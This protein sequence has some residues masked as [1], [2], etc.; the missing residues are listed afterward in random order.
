M[1]CIWTSHGSYRRTEYRNEKDLESAVLAVQQE[2][3]GSGR[4]YLDVK[5]LIGEKG[6]Q[7]NIPDGYLI[8]LSGMKPRL[9]VVENEL[10]WHEPLKHIAIQILQFSLAFESTPLLVRSV[11]LNAIN[12]SAEAQSKCEAFASARDYDNVFHL[13]DWL[14]HDHES[15]FTALVVID[16]MPPML[17]PPS[18]RRR[19]ASARLRARNPP[20][21]TVS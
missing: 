11:I 12:E 5:K 10:A 20:I 7:Q 16:E 3:F 18:H 13:V 6:V 8:D 9:F 21:L 4:V 1:D 14:V 19:T 15:P 2:L 17:E